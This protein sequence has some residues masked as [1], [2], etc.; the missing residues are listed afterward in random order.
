MFTKNSGLRLL[1]IFLE[2]FDGLEVITKCTKSIFHN[3]Q[4]Y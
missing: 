1:L 3:N 2:S 4:K